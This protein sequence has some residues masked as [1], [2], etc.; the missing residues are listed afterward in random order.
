MIFISYKTS[1]KL[2]F[3][4]ARIVID[5]MVDR[6][7]QKLYSDTGLKPARAATARS[8][9]SLST[10]LARVEKR[11]CAD[12]SAVYKFSRIPARESSNS[13]MNIK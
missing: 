6:N 3:Q 8:A 13:K 9:V 1:T 12:F 5:L 10:R 7:I 2:R 11:S 4:I